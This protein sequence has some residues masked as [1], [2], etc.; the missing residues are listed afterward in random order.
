MLRKE[1]PHQGS[2]G[3]EDH[4]EPGT[5]MPSM[6]LWMGRLPNRRCCYGW[7]QRLLCWEEGWKSLSSWELRLQPRDAVLA[8]GLQMLCQLR[9]WVSVGGCRQTLT[10][11][12][13]PLWAV[14]P[15]I[16]RRALWWPFGIKLQSVQPMSAAQCQTQL[17]LV[18]LRTWRGQCL[19]SSHSPAA[20][21]GGFYTTSPP[22]WRKSFRGSQIPAWRA[23][24]APLCSATSSW[25]PA[26]APPGPE[27]FPTSS[28]TDG[29][30]KTHWSQG[31]LLWVPLAE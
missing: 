9:C 19:G 23:S 5:T 12:R 31:S 25:G 21:T 29:Y 13:K 1:K 10:S 11:V 6:G 27:P 22:R 18:G 2:W 28:Q 15:G 14:G 3:R 16:N 26:P 24:E 8:P 7:R 20:F 30:P 4:A 17:K